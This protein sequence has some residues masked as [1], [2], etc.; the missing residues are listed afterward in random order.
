M[1]SFSYVADVE[2][3]DRTLFY[4]RSQISVFCYVSCSSWMSLRERV[5]DFMA[6]RKKWYFWMGK[7][8][9]RKYHFMK[10]MKVC[11]VLTV[12]CQR[13]SKCC[14]RFSGSKIFADDTNVNFSLP[15]DVVSS[16]VIS[17]FMGTVMNKVAGLS[18]LIRRKGA[19]NYHTPEIFYSLRNKKVYV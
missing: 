9:G 1:S 8:I 18:A 14:L 5:A 19:V 16:I 17:W 3:V 10:I 11:L 6:A 2:N 15:C 13:Y 7:E 4:L 12:L